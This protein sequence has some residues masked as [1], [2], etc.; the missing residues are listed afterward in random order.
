[1]GEFEQLACVAGGI[2][3]EGKLLAAATTSGGKL[4]LPI[5]FAALPLELRANNPAS[6]AGY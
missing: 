2:V 3:C 5:P 6:Y 1:V 4:I